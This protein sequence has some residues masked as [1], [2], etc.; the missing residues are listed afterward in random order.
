M[1]KRFIENN[2]DDSDDL[3]FD[4]LSSRYV[5]VVMDAEKEISR[6][7][8]RFDDE[9]AGERRPHPKHKWLRPETH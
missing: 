2:Y 1:N 4:M 3:T 7:R 5:K 6:H 8:A 9:V